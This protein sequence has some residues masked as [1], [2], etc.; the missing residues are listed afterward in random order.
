MESNL[1][2]KCPLKMLI[3]S[4]NKSSVKTGSSLG[5]PYDFAVPFQCVLV[6]VLKLHMYIY[7]YTYTCIYTY[8]YTISSVLLLAVVQLLSHVELFQPHGLQHATH[9]CPSLPSWIFSNSC[10]LSQW[11]YWY[12]PINLLEYKIYHKIV[13]EKSGF[14]AVFFI[15]LL[16][17]NSF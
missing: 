3:I 15:F 16:C 17:L 7:T 11:Y 4:R 14:T 13:C 10:P 2:V 8:T 6:S 9:P 1:T 5:Y 12:P